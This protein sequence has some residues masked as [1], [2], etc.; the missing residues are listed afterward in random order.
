MAGLK[1]NHV[2]KADSTVASFTKEV[3]PR[4]AKRPLK[5]NERL[6]NPGLTSSV[7]EATVAGGTTP[8]NQSSACE[9]NPPVTDGFISQRYSHAKSVSIP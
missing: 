5:I 6:A 2:I 3:N 4:L 7:K 8:Q 1:L 9:G